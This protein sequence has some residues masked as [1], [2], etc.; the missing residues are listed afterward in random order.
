MPD[1][2]PADCPAEELAAT[3]ETV[4]RESLPV[5][6][7]T[8]PRLDWAALAVARQLLGTTSEHTAAAPE[9]DTGLRDR[10]AAAIWARYPDAEPSRAG[11][12]MGNPHGLADAVLAV[13]AAPPAPTDRAATGAEWSALLNQAAD[14]METSWF[15]DEATADAAKAT[16]RRLAGEAAAGAHHPTPR[17]RCAHTDVLYGQ[18][19]RYLDDHDGDCQHERQPAAPAAPEEPTR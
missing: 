14:R 3:I 15:T 6:W 10:I 17:I 7:Q 1:T 11:L 19:V 12:V 16:M 9:P 8:P 2:T 13:L 5:W 18:C 4:L